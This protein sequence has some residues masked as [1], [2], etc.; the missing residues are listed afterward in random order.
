MRS[1]EQDAVKTFDS[2]EFFR[3]VKEQIA[4]ELSGKSFP[5]QKEFI[6]R[7]LNGEIKLQMKQ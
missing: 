3:K 7:V 4:K 2:V 6:H 1:E 5:E